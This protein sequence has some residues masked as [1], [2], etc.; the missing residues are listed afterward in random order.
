MLS[1][2]K[3]CQTVLQSECTSTHSHRQ[4]LRVLA[5]LHSCQLGIICL[6]IF[7]D[8]WGCVSSLGKYL[9]KSFCSFSYWDA[10]VTL[11]DLYKS[12]TYSG[13]KSGG[14]CILKSLAQGDMAWLHAWIKN[15]KWSV[16]SSLDTYLSSI[17]YM[18]DTMLG[19]VETI[20]K[21]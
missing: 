16:W 15:R 17:Y 1:F 12:F 3:C 21:I 18:P 6:F 10:C 19:C 8:S 13:F 11:I 20:S 4:W 2:T 9:F 7:S 14:F 5:A